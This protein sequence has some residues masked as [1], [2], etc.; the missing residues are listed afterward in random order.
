MSR[1]IETPDKENCKLMYMNKK[2][3]LH[4]DYA[5]CEKLGHLPEKVGH[6]FPGLE[7]GPNPI[8]RDDQQSGKDKFSFNELVLLD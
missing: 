4:I 3:H 5:A 7:I 2:T 8:V 6:H 1:S